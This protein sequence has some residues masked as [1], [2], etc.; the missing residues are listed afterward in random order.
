MGNTEHDQ[1]SRCIFN[2]VLKVQ[3]SVHQETQVFFCQDAFQTVG[4]QWMLVSRVIP[5]KVHDF[6]I[7]FVEINDI[8][9][10]LFLQHFE[11][12]LNGSTTTWTGQFPQF[13]IF[14]KVAEGPVHPT[15]QVANDVV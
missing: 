14:C 2:P 5:P 9:V 15:S 10:G 12:R 3:F 1:A 6:A 11:L 13:Y 7:L 8:S 4:H